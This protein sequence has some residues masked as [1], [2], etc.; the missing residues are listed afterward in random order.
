MLRMEEDGASI[1]KKGRRETQERRGGDGDAGGREVAGGD[2]GRIER[3][4]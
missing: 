2:W 1:A 4:G 3:D